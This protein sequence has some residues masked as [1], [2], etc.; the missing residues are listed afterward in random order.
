MPHSE[1]HKKKLKKNLLVLGI[2]AAL[3]ALIWAVTIIKIDRANAAEPASCGPALQS[4]AR[5][6]SS[7][8]CDIYSRQLAYRENAI[9]LQEQL[10]ARAEDFAAPR[11]QLLDAYRAD[12]KAMHDGLTP[13]SQ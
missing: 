12:L 13:K 10:D 7:P 2:I 9:D 11:R 5:E 1:L 4:E 3:V 6:A 8:I